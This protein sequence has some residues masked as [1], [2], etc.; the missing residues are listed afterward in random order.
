MAMFAM[1]QSAT[2]YPM[3]WGFRR[4]DQY[5]GRGSG[6][7]IN[8]NHLAGYL[9]MAVPVALAYTVMSRFSPTIKVLLAYSAVTMLAGIVV[10]LSRGGILAMV[11]ALVIFCG[12][13]LAQR[14]FW[15]SALV[16][17]CILTALAAVAVSQFESVQR[18]F[19]VAFKHDKVENGR[20][21]YWAAAWQLSK[22]DI[23]WGIGPGHFDVEFPSVR[24]WEVQSRP[25]YAHNDYLN[26]LCEWGVLGMSIVAAACGLLYFGV[27]QVWHALRRPSN[28]LGSRF[29]DRT[30]FV[31]GATVGLVALMLHCIVDFDMQIPA[32]AVTAVTLMALLAAQARFAT[33]RFWRN[34]GRFGKILLKS[35]AAAAIAY[36]SAQGLHKGKETY[37]L[38]RA[39]AEQT[40]PER[41]IAFATKAH[42][43]EPMDGEADYKMGDYLWS[44]SVLEGPDY[45]DRAKQAMTWYAQAMQLNPFDAYAPL[46]CGMCLDRL[47][48]TRAAKPY[49]ELAHRNDPHNT[50]IALEEGRH[51]IELGDYAA[52]KQ[53]FDDALK[54]EAS[55]VAVAETQKLE[56]IMTN[57]LFMPLAIRPPPL[58][59][60]LEDTNK[61]T[62]P[63]KSHQ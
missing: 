54:M 57:P 28:E 48:Q 49:F 34:P 4:L 42:E 12:V 1:F 58:H 56:R 60:G 18:R 43:A 40:Q 44:L 17:L 13:L 32:V 33:E 61:T 11:V 39:K 55:A 6:T 37:W 27:F 45:L 9:G 47:G 24:P 10:T 16:M 23:I 2:H 8:P 21:F 3:I 5:M 50:Y 53:W 25:H 59:A 30:A 36:L 62:Q 26:T 52:A 7:F 15:R 35:V 14:D 22:R 63:P 46:A 20:Q 31:V 38:A 19:E 41:I 51:S 29:S